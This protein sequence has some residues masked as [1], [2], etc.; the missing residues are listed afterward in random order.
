MVGR[1]GRKGASDIRTRSPHS[2]LETENESVCRP[3]C[4][5]KAIRVSIVRIVP[6]QEG[7]GPREGNSTVEDG[8]RRGVGSLQGARENG[9]RCTVDAPES[10][11]V[12]GRGS[13]GLIL[14]KW[15]GLR[16]GLAVPDTSSPE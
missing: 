3:L 16:H 12:E 4:Q 6:E 8:A 10:S 11:R 5:R 2:S 1:A 7:A 13:S 9:T 15:D 14:A